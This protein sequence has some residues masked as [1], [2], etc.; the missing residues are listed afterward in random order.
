VWVR[1][2]Q[3]NTGTDYDYVSDGSF[4]IAAAPLQGD[5]NG[6]GKVDAADYTTW[7]DTLGQMGA[8]LAADGSDNESVDEADYQLWLDHFGEAA[9][10]G[11]TGL[12]A[13][14]V[15]EPA[16]GILLLTG[17]LILSRPRYRR[18]L[19]KTAD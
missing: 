5:Y 9:G 4:S 8:G 17:L 6:N 2:Q 1:V 18:R 11:S 12:D 3:D 7:R 16:G 14:A 15:P 13:G 10:S 19:T